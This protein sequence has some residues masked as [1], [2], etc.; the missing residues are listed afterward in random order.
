MQ[1]TEHIAYNMIQC[2]HSIH[3]AYTQHTHSIH[4]AYIMTVHI[5]SIHRVH[6]HLVQHE[7]HVEHG[8][9]VDKVHARAQYMQTYVYIVY[10]YIRMH[11]KR[12]TG[13]DMKLSVLSSDY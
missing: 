8:S 12:H 2:A 6:T 7:A 4:T 9:I 10:T 13:V 1:Y 11:T 3:T 5:I